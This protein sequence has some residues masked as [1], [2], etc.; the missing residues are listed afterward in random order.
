MDEIVVISGKGGTGKTT[1][2]GA[3]ASLWEN[4]VTA[5]CD[6]DASDLHLLFNPDVKE[7]HNFFSG[8]HP[9]INPDLCTLCGQCAAVCVFGAFTPN[10]N[11]NPIACKGCAVCAYFCPEDAITPHDHLCGQWFLSDTRFGPFVHARLGIAEDNSGKLVYKIR[12]EA[13]K[14]AEKFKKDIILIDGSPGI[15]CPVM[16]SLTGAS[17]AV[18][19]TE[20]SVSGLHDLNRVLRLVEHF[21]I[22]AVVVINKYDINLET[23]NQIEK[24][25]DKIGGQI[26]G[27]IPYD[28]SIIKAMVNGQTIPEFMDGTLVSLFQSIAQRIKNRLYF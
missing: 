21:K 16:S 4:I 12:T 6:A 19:V 2:V 28:S 23:S 9:T 18:V 1:L 20:P 14:I 10:L 25:V 8:I 11:I 15:G 7:T 17:L 13:K 3:L 24:T 26:V 27:Q 5:D 22:P